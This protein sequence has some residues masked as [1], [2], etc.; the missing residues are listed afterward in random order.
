MF[1]KKYVIIELN[2]FLK[3]CT[4]K[5]NHKFILIIMLGVVVWFNELNIKDSTEKRVKLI[6]RLVK[7]KNFVSIIVIY[8]YLYKNWYF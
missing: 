1:S 4:F 5:K 3:T 2:L 8:T 6:K 7:E